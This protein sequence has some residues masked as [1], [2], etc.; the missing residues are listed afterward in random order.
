MYHTY[1]ISGGALVRS[2]TSSPDP[3]VLPRQ[4]QDFGDALVT[5]PKSHK[6]VRSGLELISIPRAGDKALLIAG[7][8]RLAASFAQRALSG[9]C[10]KMLVHSMRIALVT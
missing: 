7:V 8:S 3:K 10:D 5:P 9:I 6:P 1:D 4:W 2:N